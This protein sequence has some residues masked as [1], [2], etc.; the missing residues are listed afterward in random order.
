MR[1][2]APQTE[3]DTMSFEYMSQEG[4]DKIVAEYQQLVNVELPAPP[5]LLPEV[6]RTMVVLYTLQLPLPCL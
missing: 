5:P 2:F 3:D 4:Y 1:N 6:L